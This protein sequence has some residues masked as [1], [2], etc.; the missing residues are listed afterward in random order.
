M[1]VALGLE[2]AYLLFSFLREYDANHPMTLQGPGFIPGI[3]GWPG[4]QNPGGHHPGGFP[5]GHPGGGHPGGFPGGGHPG[6][7]HP[8]GFPGSPG[9][10]GFPSVPGTEGGWPPPLP[11]V[12]GGGGHPP[13]QPQPTA[14]TQA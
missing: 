5:G 4:A 9:G 3:T 14:P 13:P 1:L 8:G 2:L 12:P 7:G 10:G 6:G 11:G